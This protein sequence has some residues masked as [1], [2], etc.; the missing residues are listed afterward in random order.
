MKF[1]RFDFYMM[2]DDV[3]ILP[4]FRISKQMELMDKNFNIQFHFVIWHF[5]WRWMNN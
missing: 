2:K 4:T 3:Y 5:R 1:E